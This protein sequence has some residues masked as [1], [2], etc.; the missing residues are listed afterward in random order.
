[1]TTIDWKSMPHGVLRDELANGLCERDARI[2]DLAA[3]GAPKAGR[4]AKNIGPRIVLGN[5]APRGDLDGEGEGDEAL[6]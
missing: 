5:E 2:K 3:L 1:M 6:Q 4:P